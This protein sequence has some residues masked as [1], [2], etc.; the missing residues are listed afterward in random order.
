MSKSLI[1]TTSKMGRMSIPTRNEVIRLHSKGLT[2]VQIQSELGRRDLTVSRL[3]IYKLLKK[4]QTA[5]KVADLPRS[6]PSYGKN[7]TLE[8][9]NFIDKEMYN[10]DHLTAPILMEKVNDK[11][12]VNFSV[13]KIKLIRKKLGWRSDSTAYC[14]LIKNHNIPKRL[15]Y[16]RERIAAKDEF[17]DAMFSDECTIKMESHGKITFRKWYEPKKFKPK[18]KHPY[19]LHVW[20]AISR[21]GPSR[22]VIFHGIMRSQFFVD[23]ILSAA[24]EFIDKKFPNSP[25]RYIQDNDPKHTSK[26]TKKAYADL[27][28]NWYKTPAESPDMNPI[29][30]LWHELKTFLR[31]RIRPKTKD[32]LVN[33]IGEFWSEL[34]KAR[35][36]RYID[37]LKKVF[38]A[39]V[40]HEGLTSGY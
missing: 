12:D 38:P 25:H 3:S 10:D 8:V 17:N 23:E 20:A 32:E 6:T 11:F 16:A 4:W 31:T 7:V 2:V 13:S 40:E 1:S 34:D 29:E 37:H 14:Q 26:L 18:P 36:G 21:K 24:K 35:C 33:G 30:N 22:I 27:G 15:K 19:K 28:I 39:V 9:L 5:R